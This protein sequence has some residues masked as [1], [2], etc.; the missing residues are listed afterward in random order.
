L[1]LD[2]LCIFS[3]IFIE[4]KEEQETL[5]QEDL[6]SQLMDRCS[7]AQRDIEFC[8][9]PNKGRMIQWE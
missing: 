5:H 1:M 9:N 7:W 8:V 6:P 4:S 2:S 3:Y